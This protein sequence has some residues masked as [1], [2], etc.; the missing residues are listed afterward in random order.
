MHTQHKPELCANTHCTFR[1]KTIIQV[2]D[3]NRGTRTLPFRKGA[4]FPVGPLLIP[5]SRNVHGS[6]AEASADSVETLTPAC[7]REST[8]GRRELGP[9]GK[10][11]PNAR[12]GGFNFEYAACQGGKLPRT[13]MQNTTTSKSVDSCETFNSLKSAKQSS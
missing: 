4:A 1:K 12:A 2:N 8:A 11:N 13:T 7:K 5:P 9:L 6:V 3:S 10:V